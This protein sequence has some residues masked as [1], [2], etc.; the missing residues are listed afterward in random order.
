MPA[1][2]G[3]P[4]PSTT[5]EPGLLVIAHRGNAS[6]A[7]GNTM[8]AVEGAW[9]AGADL[10]EVDLRLTQEGIGVVIHDATV[11]RTTTAAGEVS[12]MSATEL[13]RLDAGTPF[14][15]VFAGT[16]V[17]LLADVAEFLADHPGTDLLLEL[18]GDYTEAQAAGV[19]STLAAAGMS[20]RTVVQTF[21]P[22]TIRSLRA[23]DS[24]VRLGLLVGSHVAPDS[25][26]L[27]LST[28]VGA[29]A[30]N[31]RY[32]LIARH[33]E[34]VDEIHAAGMQVFVW[35]LNEPEQWAQALA[36]GVD[37]IITDRPDRL[38]GWLT[39]TTGVPRPAPAVV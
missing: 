14:S 21:W 9:R 27:P 20:D 12:R 30:C 16:G 32:D 38:A 33:P 23:T 6:V 1:P 15:S 28:E 2:G 26:M 34:V 35:T 4:A 31:P 37:G 24:G 3:E 19:L 5:A 10:V 7:P 29:F 18:K 13:A 25:V 8:P 17:P 11:D 39:A 36:W 22:Q